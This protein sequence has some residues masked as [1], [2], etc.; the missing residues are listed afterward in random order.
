MKILLTENYPEI[1]KEYLDYLKTNNELF[2]IE[3]NFSNNEIESAII[4]SNTKIDSD[5]LDKYTSLKYIARVGVG[6][7][8]IDLEECKSRNIKV[9]NTPFANMDSVAD[10]VL[11]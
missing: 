11:T 9:L 8:K 1:K 4:R 6:L 3:D 2:Y 5:F 7:D 10:L